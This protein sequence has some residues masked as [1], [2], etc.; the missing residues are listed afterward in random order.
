MGINKN[1]GIMIR[2]KAKWVK[3]GEKTLNISIT[4]KSEVQ[5]NLYKAA[6]YR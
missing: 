3:E 5:L 1:N 6:N 4:Q 2:S